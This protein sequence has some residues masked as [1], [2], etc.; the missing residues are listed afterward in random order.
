M[1]TGLKIFCNWNWWSH[2]RCWRRWKNSWRE[3]IKTKRKA[4]TIRCLQNQTNTDFFNRNEKGFKN[5]SFSDQDTD[6]TLFKKPHWHNLYEIFR[7]KC[8]GHGGKVLGLFISSD[9]ENWQKNNQFGVIAKKSH[10]NDSQLLAEYRIEKFFNMQ[11][12]VAVKQEILLKRNKTF[13][14]EFLHQID[15]RSLK[16]V[17]ILLNFYV[18]PADLKAKKV[19]KSKLVNLIQ[20]RIIKR[21]LI[22]VWL[23]ITW[24]TRFL[25]FWLILE[26]KLQIIKI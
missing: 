13:Q 15:W 1:L 23:H 2:C 21:N 24:K 4:I 10:I 26:I 25:L 17:P 9:F 7:R 8:S 11:F 3:S 18:I 12:G 22:H 19:N 20:K 6:S 5:E 16:L 14:V